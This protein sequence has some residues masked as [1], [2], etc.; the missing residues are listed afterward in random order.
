MSAVRSDPWLSLKVGEEQYEPRLDGETIVDAK[1]RLRKRALKIANAEMGY[2]LI[3]G[4]TGDLFV[5]RMD[6]WPLKKLAEWTCLVVGQAMRLS[7]FPTEE[8]WRI[9]RQRKYQLETKRLGHFVLR[10]MDGE[11]WVI[12][13]R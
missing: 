7:Q 5:R 1:E 2:F 8:T 12:R 11:L 3:K 6:H 10:D 4:E 13:D 9:A